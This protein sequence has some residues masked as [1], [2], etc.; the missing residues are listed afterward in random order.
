[1]LRGTDHRARRYRRSEYD[2]GSGDLKSAVWK[3][4]LLER[5]ARPIPAPA[6]REQVFGISKRV[7]L[8]DDGS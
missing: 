5:I 6:K 3:P 4:L 1:M 2:R 8:A 7:L